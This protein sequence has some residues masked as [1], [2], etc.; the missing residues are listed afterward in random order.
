MK[1]LEYSKKDNY[2]DLILCNGIRIF[3]RDKLICIEFFQ[4]WNRFQ[5]EQ[6]TRENISVT[7]VCTIDNMQ[8]ILVYG[9]Q[10]DMIIY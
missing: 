9:N 7:P 3:V 1:C 10:Q 5:G 8:I 2:D 6:V 4:Q